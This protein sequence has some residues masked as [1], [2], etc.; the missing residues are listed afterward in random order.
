[1][2]RRVEPTKDAVRFS[3]L[4]DFDQPETIDSY[5]KF[6]T[7][8]VTPLIPDS[9]TVVIHGH[10]DIVGEEEYND[11][12]SSQRAQDTKNII[13]RAI[14]NS[15]K[16]GITFQTFGLGENLQFAPFDNYFPEERFYNRTVIIDIVPD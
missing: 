4:F 10:T 8:V 11:S 6:L 12:L 1:L 2:V 15:G 3:I 14:S 5:E 16:H 13:E 7:E 9:G